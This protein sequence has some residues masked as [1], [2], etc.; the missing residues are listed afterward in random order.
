MS[1]IDVKDVSRCIQ[2]MSKMYADL[3]IRMRSFDAS[4]HT[5]QSAT[6]R[7]QRWFLQN[8][9][10]HSDNARFKLTLVDNDNCNQSKMSC[11]QHNST[12]PRHFTWIEPSSSM[13]AVLVGHRQPDASTRGGARTNYAAPTTV[14]STTC[15]AV[16]VF[17]CNA[18]RAL[19]RATA[20]AMVW[21]L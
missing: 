1:T 14:Q 19:S 12:P 16:L 13:C 11:M 20:L 4:R 21:A 17:G 15:V 5:K 6:L 18:L 8:M 7:W 9:S 2:L 3:A 10:Q